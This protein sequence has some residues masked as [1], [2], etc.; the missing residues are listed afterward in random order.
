MDE[1]RKPCIAVSPRQRRPAELLPCQALGAPGFLAECIVESEVCKGAFS[2]ELIIGIK[3]GG[4]QTC[5]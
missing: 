5:L 2:L 3:L 1:G 4:L